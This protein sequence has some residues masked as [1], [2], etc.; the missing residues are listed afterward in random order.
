MAAVFILLI[1]KQ[2]ADVAL[3]VSVV[4]IV[5]I[6]A[7]AMTY[8]KPVVQY[9]SHR[10]TLCNINA[11]VLTPLF[12]TIAVGIV[13]QIVAG[14]CTD[15]GEQAMAKAIELC[16]SIVALYVSLPLIKAVFELFDSI[17]QGG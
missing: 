7:G 14:I 3:L 11:A 9:I 16:G 2:N 6:L 13:C 8:V 12:K 4:S 17:L 10:Q 15:A 1:R 5:L